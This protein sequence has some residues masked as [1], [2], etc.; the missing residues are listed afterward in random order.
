MF[1]ERRFGFSA[2]ETGLT[3]TFSAIAGGLLQGALGKL[4]KRF[5]ERRLAMFGFGAMAVGCGLLGVTH[6]IPMLLGL[7]AIGGIGQTLTRPSITTLLTKSVG[8]DEQGAVLGVS[9]SLTSIA[10]IAMPLAVGAL[11]N[12]GMLV[13]WGM[14]AGLWAAAG[15]LM[16]LRD[17]AAS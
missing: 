12:R 4:V 14:T 8:P 6:G 17:P 15:A 13:A 10:Q 2:K 3:F 16:Q 7:I 11:I 5:G 9:Q 1:L